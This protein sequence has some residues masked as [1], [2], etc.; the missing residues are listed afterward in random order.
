VGD[1]VLIVDDE[2]AISRMVKRVVQI[3]GRRIDTAT[4]AEEALPKVDD[5]TYDLYILDKNLPGMNGIDLA[6]RVRAVDR[7]AAI[8]ILTGFASREG[9]LDAL[10]VGVDGYVEKPVKREALLQRVDAALE[11]ARNRRNLSDRLRTARAAA[12]SALDQLDRP[13]DTMATLLAHPDASV[14]TQLAGHL[15]GAVDIVNDVEALQARLAGVPPDLLVVDTALAD[16]LTPIL[17]A[18]RER[19]PQVAVVVTG[20]TPS[21]QQVQALIF[22]GV[23]A[24]VEEPLSKGV[25]HDRLTQ[26]LARLRRP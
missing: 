23:R 7:A 24:V 13:A 5:D 21:L 26:V 22:S 15:G 4:S 17:R 9:A 11:A 20:P 3:E 12:R 14:A 18:A 25:L 8:L 6:A 19:H 2:P 10:H 1:R 16:D